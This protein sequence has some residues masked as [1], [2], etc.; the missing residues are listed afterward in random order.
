MPSA[1]L[2]WRELDWQQYSAD[3]Q[4]TLL[5]QFVEDDRRLD[6][7]FE[8]PP[9]MRLALIRLAPES[10][11]AVW[12]H[13]H[14]LMDGWCLPILL[15]EVLTEYESI[16]LGQG[17][18]PKASAPYRRYVAWL[19][20]GD[21]AASEDFWRATLKGFTVPTF[22]GDESKADESTGVGE[23]GASTLTISAA[24]TAAIRACA[25]RYHV[26]ENTLV[27]GAWALLLSRYR[28][29]TDMV[30]G[31]TVSGRSGEIP[32]IESMVGLFINTLQ[33]IH[34]SYLFGR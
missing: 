27:Q 8:Q 26:T 10:Y 34:G 24:T 28:G 17:S 13:H 21:Q 12:T 3:E 15:K 4:Q 18:A 29:V 16:R 30:F 5:R 32:G 2:P 7:D 9:L 11:E 14:I 31:T 23:Y 33:G 6:F 1:E 22:L 19:Q 20:Q 25:Q